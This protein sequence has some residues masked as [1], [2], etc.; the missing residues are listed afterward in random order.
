MLP[1][2]RGSFEKTDDKQKEEHLNFETDEAM[3]VHIDNF[4]G[5]KAYGKPV[6]S[7]RIN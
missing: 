1:S 3:S 4:E 2:E 7:Y 6:F 5:L